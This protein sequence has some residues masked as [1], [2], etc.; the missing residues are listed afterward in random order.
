MFLLNCIGYLLYLY[1]SLIFHSCADLSNCTLYIYIDFFIHIFIDSLKYL[2]FEDWVHKTRLPHHL[3]LYRAR[4]VIG[5]V[6]MW[7]SS[8]ASFYDCFLDFKVVLTV[9]F[10]AF[11]F[12]RTYYS[13]FFFLFSN[14]VQRYEYKMELSMCKRCCLVQ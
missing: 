14:V 13:P 6:F 1:M 12:I 5:D 11:H 7:V 10:I 3:W 4:K 2:A 9:I 8:L